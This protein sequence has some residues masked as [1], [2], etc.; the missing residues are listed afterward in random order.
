VPG[1]ATGASQPGD[2][3]QAVRFAIEVAKAFGR[4]RCRFHDPVEW[5]AIQRRY[6]SMGH[7]M[8]AG[9]E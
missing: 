6:G 1:S 4:G 2:I 7:L 5:E 3:E 9:R 8:T